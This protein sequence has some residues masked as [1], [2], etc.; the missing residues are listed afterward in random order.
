MVIKWTRCDSLN[1]SYH[2]LLPPVPGYILH[3]RHS[4]HVLASLYVISPV[5]FELRRHDGNKN[6]KLDSS[7]WNSVIADFRPFIACISGFLRSCDVDGSGD[8]ARSEWL[9][10]FK[11]RGWC[12]KVTASICGVSVAYSANPRSLEGRG[13][14]IDLPATIILALNFCSLNDCQ[15]L[16]HNRSLFANTPFDTN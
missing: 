11:F 13:G 1:P 2:I 7:E 12:N 8:I 9:E 6:G 3:T 10:G 15:E 14:Q 5:Q 4:L 16:R